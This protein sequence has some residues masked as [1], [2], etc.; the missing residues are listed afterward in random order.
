M[1]ALS[2]S[3]YRDEFLHDERAK[4]KKKLTYYGKR[5]LTTFHR[6]HTCHNEIFL[7]M[8]GGGILHW[9]ETSLSA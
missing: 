2:E 7:S 9:K 6:M 8:P 5:I 4:K 3:A 1:H